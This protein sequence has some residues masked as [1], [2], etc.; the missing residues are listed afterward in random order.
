M[1]VEHN[2]F[3]AKDY[4]SLGHV[5]AGATTRLLSITITV[6]SEGITPSTLT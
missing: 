4:P 2:S 3:H 5:G 6:L 1:G